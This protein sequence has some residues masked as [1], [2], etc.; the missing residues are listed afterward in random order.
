MSRVDDKRFKLSCAKKNWE[1]WY[2]SVAEL[3]GAVREE[4]SRAT[5]VCD[6]YKCGGGIQEV[7]WFCPRCGN[8][9]PTTER[10]LEA[11]S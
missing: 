2:R 10:N 6:N 4:C 7:V 3:E 11:K 1:E 9:A 5:R 8:V